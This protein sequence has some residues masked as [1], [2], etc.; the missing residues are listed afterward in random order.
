MA[1]ASQKIH[2]ILGFER[3]KAEFSSKTL[4]FVTYDVWDDQSEGP[5]LRSIEDAVGKDRVQE[6]L[7]K[8]NRTTMPPE[9]VIGLLFNFRKTVHMQSWSA[10]G[11]NSLMWD[12][13]GHSGR[14][15]RIS[16]VRSKIEQ[17]GGLTIHKVK[18]KQVGLKEQLSEV[19]RYGQIRLDELFLRKKWQF[20]HEME[21]RLI[22][23]SDTAWLA[24]ANLIDGLSPFVIRASCQGLVDQGAMTK[25]EQNKTVDAWV[26]QHCLKHVPFGH[27][28]G[29][30]ESILVGPR[31]D[32]A[33]VNEVRVFCQENGIAFSGKSKILQ[34]ELPA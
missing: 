28:G 7:A 2:R 24:K 6:W 34:F 8:N 16:T 10:Q 31:A 17:I 12:A 11:E 9:V 5:I 3:F 26:K 15:I 27:V 25:E 23:D 21:L 14:A 29:F 32:E 13:Y 1:N 20:R 33:F 18:Y 19:F 30:I 4:G 22:A